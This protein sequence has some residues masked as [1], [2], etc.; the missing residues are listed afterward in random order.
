[1]MPDYFLADFDLRKKP[2]TLRLFLAKGYSEV[3]YIETVLSLR[4]A[5]PET[6]TIL[7]FKGVDRMSG[8]ARTIVKFLSPQM[9]EQLRAIGV[10]ADCEDNPKGRIDVII[11]CG[12]AFG[13]KNCA[14]D[15]AKTSRH[16]ANGRKFAL[17]VSPAPGRNGR[18]ETLILQEKSQDA[19]MR[20]ISDS[21]PCISA[22]N[23]GRS[24]DEKAIVQ[25]FISASMNNSM[26]GIAHAFRGSLFDVNHQAYQNH[27]A[28]VDYVLA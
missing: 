26:A 19:T 20:C 1:M 9:L 22:A 21:L 15:L 8:H 14:S 25:M 12:K 5:D 4:M 3:G 13:F 17:S 23:N 24:V 28:M 2:R 16:S 6:T 11:E 27:I 7:C 18:I 10:L